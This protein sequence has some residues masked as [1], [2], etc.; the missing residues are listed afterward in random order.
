VLNLTPN[1]FNYT[2]A[3]GFVIALFEREPIPNSGRV[4]F[5]Q[6][7]FWSR[8]SLRHMKPM[9]KANRKIDSKRTKRYGAAVA[10]AGLFGLFLPIGAAQ[11]AG[12][13]AILVNDLGDSSV[14]DN[15]TCTLRGAIGKANIDA[16][17]DVIQFGLAGTISLAS[18]LNI[19]GDTT[20]NGTGMAITLNGT[21]NVTM[22]D[23]AANQSV[24]IDSLTITGVRA[25]G[26]DGSFQSMVGAATSASVV[27]NAGTLTLSNNTFSGLA[28][29]AGN[30]TD[31]RTSMTMTFGVGGAATA[32]IV[33]NVGVARLDN[34]T[35]NTLTATAGFGGVGNAGNLGASGGNADTYVVNNLGAAT[36]NNNTFT[37]LSATGGT[38]GTG[39]NSGTGGPGGAASLYIL[40]N[41][42]AGFLN[43]NSMTAFRATPGTVGDALN[44]G[45]GG[46]GG[47]AAA[48]SSLEVDD[49]TAPVANPTSSPTP[50]TAGWNNSP[51]TITWRWA[52]S[53]SGLDTANC[54]ATS[55]VSVDGSTTV[56]SSCADWKGNTASANT[57]VKVDMT[58]PTVTVTGVTDGA[59]YASNAVPLAGCSSVDAGS[60]IATTAS[61][62]TSGTTSVTV[63]CAGAA[64]NAGNTQTAAVTATYAVT[65]PGASSTTVAPTTTTQ[66][67]TPT[68]SDPAPTITP[69]AVIA[70]TTTV[71][72]TTTTAASAPVAANSAPAATTTVPALSPNVSVNGT[73]NAP[74]TA[75]DKLKIQGSGYK[76]GSTVTVELHSDPIKLG[77][78]VVDS[79]GS[80]TFEAEVPVGF[81]GQHQIVVLGTAINGDP[82]S[83]SSPVNVAPAA[84]VVDQ[85]ALTG[86]RSITQVGLSFLAIAVGALM[87]ACTKR[88]R[89][90][91]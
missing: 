69:I 56:S 41:V 59:S 54:P 22:F 71:T 51:V 78:V 80:F 32:S 15:T 74:V 3:Y 36:L 38:G 33:N 43:G 73:A 48:N 63:T 14:C 55:T 84:A 52:D 79:T 75:G 26:N 17:A 21:T 62:T 61:M 86:Q 30:Q 28:A 27:N 16:G 85:L 42:G 49:S 50:N 64:D 39:N 25:V 2:F 46:Q 77:S 90:T 53:G 65:S 57:P 35:F 82:T 89:P 37:G 45:V 5:P 29:T 20:I 40:R 67:P 1:R 8:R 11:G 87:L 24:T 60:G 68:T 10:A 83:V 7:F 6:V 18:T 70:A 12:N 88:P 81:V 44:G 47:A 66:A 76:P 91:K 4:I 58:R 19:T 9:T 31:P 34:N 23:V 72:P 13:A